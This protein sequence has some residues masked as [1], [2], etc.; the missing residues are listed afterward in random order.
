MVDGNLDERSREWVEGRMMS[1]D[2]RLSIAARVGDP[3]PMRNS[4][5]PALDAGRVWQ[6]GGLQVFLS[7]DRLKAENQRLMTLV[8]THHAPDRADRL[9][10]G[11]SAAGFAPEP[12]AAGGYEGRFVASPDGAGYT[13][14]YAI[15]WSTLGV[16]DD[17][18][19]AVAHAAP[20]ASFARIDRGIV[21]GRRTA[22]VK[23]K[24][25]QCVAADHR[26]DLGRRQFRQ[27]G[28]EVS[29]P[30]PIADG[31]MPRQ[32]ALQRCLRPGNACLT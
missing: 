29:V 31:E 32:R 7:A 19:R 9:Y 22:S 3:L 13:R 23:I 25:G 27:A 8:M 10:L 21:F 28:E 5:D 16:D 18:P 15:P 26:L 4:V 12:V 14:E 20:R 24:E 30:K 1:E 17:P 6:G 11:R 2:E